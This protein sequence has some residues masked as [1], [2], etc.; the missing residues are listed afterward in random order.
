M[1]LAIATLATFSGVM[2]NSWILLDD[3]EYV[4]KNPYVRNGWT[5][6]GAAWFLREPQGGNWH[7]LTSYSHM[8]TVQAFGAN[9]AAHHAVDLAI[10]TLNGLL[11]LALLWGLTRAWWRS[12]LVAALFALHPLRVESVAWIAERKDVLSTFFFLLALIAYVRWTARPG[13]LRWWALVAAFVL[14]LLSKPML[15]TLP[16]VLLLLDAWPLGRLRAGRTGDARSGAKRGPSA[17]PARSL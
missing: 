7:P 15:V 4:F 13:A 17:V 11:L 6:R 9:P 1:L 5:W 3:P 8:L 14:G 10:H 12:L 2:R 16:F